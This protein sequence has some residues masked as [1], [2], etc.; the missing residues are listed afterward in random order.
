MMCMIFETLLAL[1]SSAVVEAW[2]GPRAGAD[3]SG[4]FSTRVC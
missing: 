2:W 1:A 4:A 3:V